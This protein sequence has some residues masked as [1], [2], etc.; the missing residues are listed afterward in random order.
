MKFTSLLKGAALGV[1]LFAVTNEASAQV[2]VR[3]QVLRL[4]GTSAGTFSQQAAATTTSYTLTWPAAVPSG[5]SAALAGA[6]GLLRVDGTGAAD[7]FMIGAGEQLVS[8]DANGAA[9]QVA[10]FTD[11][12]TITSAPTMTFNGTTGDLTLGNGAQDGDLILISSGTGNPAVTINAVADNAQTWQYPDQGASTGPFNFVG[13]TDLPT[14]GQIPVAQADGTVQWVDNPSAFFKAGTVTPASGAY[15]A[16]VTFTT[17]YAA[18]P[19]V[20]VTAVGPTANG[21]ILQAT[22]VTTGGFTILS[23]APFD[24]TDVIH[25]HANSAYNP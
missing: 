11:G 12:N 15:T 5:T 9:G 7:W 14:T 10:Y 8:V 2:P 3:T 6:S 16:T 20:T 25:W 22:S 17:A 24:G 13:T 1:A 21:Y 23:T 4:I 18:A 19:I